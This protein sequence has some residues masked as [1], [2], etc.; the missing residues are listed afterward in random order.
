MPSPIVSILPEFGWHRVDTADRVVWFKGHLVRDG[1]TYDRVEG[2]RLF[3]T[4]GDVPSETIGQHLKQID[5]HFAGVV[6]TPD[7]LL[8]AVDRIRSIPLFYAETPQGLCIDSQARRLRTR[9]NADG[10]DP[11]A[12]LEIAMGGFSTGDSTLFSE[13]R[14]IV[15]GSFVLHEGREVR[16]RR[17]YTYDA[18]RLGP[19]RPRRD[20]KRGLEEV[21]RAIFRKMVDGLDGRLV[22][23][24]LSAGLDSR[25][26]ASALKILNYKNVI[27]FAYGRPGNHEADTSRRVAEALGFPWRF[28]PY[29][30]RRVGQ[31]L[32]SA[33]YEEHERFADTC[34]SVP[35]TQDFLAVQELHASGEIPQDAVFINGQSGDFITGNHIPKVLFQPTSVESAAV[36]RKRIIDA[37]ILKHF[38]LWRDLSTAENR[39]RIAVRLAAGL[40][41]ANVPQDLEADSDHGAYELSEFHERQSKFV[42]SGQRVYESFGYDWRL[43][44][45][46][47]DFIDFWRPLSLAAKREQNLYAEFLSEVN[48]GNVWR[49]LRVKSYVSP[50][51]AGALR[52]LTK[53][54]CAP[55]G[56]A[57]WHE[58][59]RRIFAYWTHITS[60]TAYVPYSRLV[61]DR[62]G[63]RNAVSLRAE[64]YLSEKGL[65]S[66][67]TLMIGKPT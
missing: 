29:N 17:Y 55:L 44:L 39:Q 11:E 47:V 64:R 31:A 35:F 42:V 34:A 65:A 28:I 25:L 66:N 26:I 61:F 4:L 38:S 3:G 19:D 63:F 2:A 40:R 7:R 23:L 6:Q 20:L 13:L 33:A 62:R 43:P 45:W 59:D 9:V 53:Y 46:D 27:C 14:Q 1:R 41:D 51:W 21:T 30:P 16:R 56:R 52:T 54:A 57:V 12:A 18:W 60:T 5:G 32:K 15:G 49:P 36:R 10:I 58:I 37:L 67:G 22:M 24:P 50:R 48:W 8:A